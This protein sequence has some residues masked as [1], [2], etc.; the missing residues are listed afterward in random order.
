MRTLLII[1]FILWCAEGNAQLRIPEAYQQDVMC[2]QKHLA[3]ARMQVINYTD[4]RN[5]D[6]SWQECN[7][8]ILPEDGFISGL[9][10]TKLTLVEEADHFYLDCSDSLT[11]TSVTSGATELLFE[12]SANALRINL[13]ASFEAGT[14]LFIDVQYFGFPTA[15]GFG[16]FM[17]GENEAGPLIW[18]L[19]EPYGANDWFPC[20]QSLDDKLDSIDLHIT[21]P[22]IYQTGA[23]GML[24]NSYDPGEGMITYS[25]RHNYPIATYLIGIVIGQLEEYSFYHPVGD[26]SLL[27]QNMVY[28][29]SM[30]DAIGGIDAFLP[31]FDL[32]NE[33][34]GTYPFILEKY[35]HMQ[36]GRGGGMEHQ[37]M[38][39]ITNYY[40]ELLVH[41]A[42]HQWFGN[43]VTCG[44]WRDIWLNEGF[45]TYTTWMSF[46]LLGDPFNYYEGWLNTGRDL[47]V[48]QPGGSVWVDDTTSVPR[49]FDRRLTY[50]KGA[51][52]LH[53]LRWEIGDEAFFDALYNYIN[54]P[55]LVWGF[56]TADDFIAHAESSTDTSLSEFFDDWYYG[57]G[58]PVYSVFW[59]Q[60]TSTGLTTITLSQQPTD[61]S[62]DFFDMHVPIRLVGAE[63]SMDIIIDN[64]VNGQ[65]ITVYPTFIIDT[66]K[67]DP[68]I[69]L[70]HAYDA[71][72]KVPINEEVLQVNIYPNPATDQINLQLLEP[73]S[74][75]YTLTIWD[76]KADKVLQQIFTTQNG[77]GLI[78]INTHGWAAGQYTV[79]IQ[80]SEK[81]LVRTFI[82]STHN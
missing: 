23:P 39:S 1:T 62:V 49:I 48:S 17:Q 67:L 60:D 27:M 29:E 26:V 36:F 11:V 57:S 19:S 78:Q 77:S 3:E 64:K 10:T 5:Y 28:A 34:Y 74:D 53:M 61:T 76:A 42:T 59:Q 20:K 58:F 37:T 7:W 14:T 35:G 52:I 9:V 54:D 56:A 22:N 41:E 24:I 70:L 40:Y 4:T 81:E 51:W 66:I 47:V 82:V 79:L 6:I 63:D 2:G 31:A 18:T 50:Y 80:G 33:L 38:S 45:A 16:S 32:L 15:S 72:V 68:E 12:H 69:K 8:T 75:T 46:E 73:E 55:E 44:S 43:K 30:D 71:I 21:V 65:I 13:G 25:W